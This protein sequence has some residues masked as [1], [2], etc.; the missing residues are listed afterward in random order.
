MSAFKDAVAADIKRVFINPLEFADAH[1]ING[2][3]V[4]AVIDSD[5]LKERQTPTAT[6]YAEG[7]MMGELLVYVSY[8]D[9]G[10][11]PVRGEQMTID[12]VIYYVVES[13]V[14]MGVL[15]ITVQGSEG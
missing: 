4:Q 12:G 8:D 6:D 11:R 13:V 3:T 15:E 7:V 2:Q 9:I 5:V 1:E 10:R 14:N